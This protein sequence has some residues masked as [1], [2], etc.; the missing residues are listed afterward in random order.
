MA[1]VLN[2]A[3]K[4]DSAKLLHYF[5]PS[6]ISISRLSRSLTRS[7]SKRS[8]DGMEWNEIR[9]KTSPGIRCTSSGLRAKT[10]DGML[11]AAKIPVKNF[12]VPGQSLF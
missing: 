8:P 12:N 3:E 4:N 7:D 5:I 6:M 2:E 1:R 9:E 11:N 10:L